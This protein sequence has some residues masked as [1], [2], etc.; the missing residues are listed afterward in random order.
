[1]YVLL[2]K[3]R[4]LP[5]ALAKK[6][7]GLI[8]NCRELVNAYEVCMYVYVYLCMCVLMYVCTYVCVYVRE[9]EREIV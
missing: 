9:T 4:W 1:M 3:D 2:R 6:L 7:V 8:N 5:E